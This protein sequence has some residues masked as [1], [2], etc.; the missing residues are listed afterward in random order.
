MTGPT[1]GHPDDPFDGDALDGTLIARRAGAG[2]S[3]SSTRDAGTRADAFPSDP[4]AGPADPD[5]DDDLDDATH[6]VAR[7]GAVTSGV[8]LLHA[9]LDLDAETGS[10]MVVRRES[11]RRAEAAARGSQTDLDHT[12]PGVAV[13]PLPATVAG[14]VPAPLERLAH[15]PA[16]HEAPYAA[17]VSSPA[18]AT[19]SA[20]PA[21]APQA[22]ADGAASE[23]AVRR[24]ARRL[25]AVVVAA[26]ST[27][28]ILAVAT[29]IVLAFAG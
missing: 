29:V 12:I 8:E 19:R 1:G 13:R 17:R 5:A 2:A 18:V 4:D 22:L 24:R 10:T 28:V 23:A 21:H 15:S 6:L 11:R 26:A 3:A 14:D 27:V 16:I 25:A 20:V 7:A 9:P